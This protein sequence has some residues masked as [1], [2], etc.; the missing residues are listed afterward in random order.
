MA[1]RCKECV[2]KDID[3][4]EYPCNDCNEIMDMKRYKDSVKSHFTGWSKESINAIKNSKE[5]LKK[6]LENI[7]N[8]DL[9]IHAEFSITY[10]GNVMIT[11]F[12]K[13]NIREVTI[14]QITAIGDELIEKT[15]KLDSKLFTSFKKFIR[16]R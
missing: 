1:T 10:D 6:R 13:D 7:I 8:P 14:Y 16:V 15:I 9:R 5:K 3:G 4:G 11:A 12:S 2:F